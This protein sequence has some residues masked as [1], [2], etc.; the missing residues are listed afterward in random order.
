[1]VNQRYLQSWISWPGFYMVNQRYLHSPDIFNT[2]SVEPDVTN[3]LKKQTYGGRK[4][5][6]GRAQGKVRS[7]E[8]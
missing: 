2:A 3:L 7:G 1:M 8:G 4:E 5:H 6:E